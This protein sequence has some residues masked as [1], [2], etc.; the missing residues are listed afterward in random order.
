MQKGVISVIALIILI[1]GG[2][3]LFGGAL[4]TGSSSSAGEI[5]GARDMSQPG[6]KTAG[7]TQAATESTPPPTTETPT[8]S[9]A[10][11]QISVTVNGQN[12]SFSPSV[13]NAKKGDVITV[14]FVN[15]D[16][17]HD[18][19]IDGYNVGTNQIASGETNSFTF[20]AD[21]AGSFEYYCSVSSHRAMGMRG[22][23]VVAE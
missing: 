20:T 16:G 22:T 18:L 7:Q 21:K 5:T 1:G 17:F 6:N 14:N 4:K 2:Y 19:R 13:I 23:L 11:R 15:Q 9:A 10:A 8:G 3:W 12:F